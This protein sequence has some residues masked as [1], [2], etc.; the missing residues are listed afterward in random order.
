[1]EHYT[2]PTSGTAT[3]LPKAQAGRSLPAARTVLLVIHPEQLPPPT[4]AAFQYLSTQDGGL[5]VLQDCLIGGMRG[6]A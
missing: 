6:P 3:C 5:P 4:G 2:C 1:M